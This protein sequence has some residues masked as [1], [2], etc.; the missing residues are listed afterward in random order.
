[1]IQKGKVVKQFLEPNYN[2]LSLFEMN[3]ILLDHY[4]GNGTTSMIH[5]STF[6]KH[7]LFDETIGYAEDYELWLRLCLINKYKL[8]LIPKILAKYRVHETQ[9]TQTKIGKSLEK[10]EKIRSMILKKM[11]FSEQEKYRKALKEFKK[12]KPLRIKI[13]HRM[14]DI[15]FRVLPKSASESIVR[16]YFDK[17]KKDQ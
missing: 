2:K 11:E 15:M 9:L 3:V 7:G 13:R 17:I 4:V 5:K 14:R 16:G 12:N 8:H 6:E 10:D 1:M